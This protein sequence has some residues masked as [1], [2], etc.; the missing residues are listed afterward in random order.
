MEVVALGVIVKREMC[1]AC[2]VSSDVGVPVERAAIILL[3][4]QVGVTVIWRI[5][6]YRWSIALNQYLMAEES[7]NIIT[8]WKHL[9]CVK[10]QLYSA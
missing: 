1:V 4:R 8:R 5:E 10:I 2:L 3:H 7:W 9:R 6:L